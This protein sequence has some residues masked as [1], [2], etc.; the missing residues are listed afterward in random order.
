MD[1]YAPY[2]A[3]IRRLLAGEPRRLLGWQPAQRSLE[4][5]ARW[6][7]EHSPPTAG[8]WDASAR[9][10]YGVLAAWG[11]GHVL[12]YV[13]QR[14]VVQDNFGD[15]VGVRNFALAEAYFAQ[16]SEEQALRI[17]RELR[18]RYVLVRASGSGHSAGYGARSQFARL[19]ELRGAE[20]VFGGAPGAREQRIRALAHHRLIF[21]AEAVAGLSAGSRPSYKIFEIV[22]GA[23]IAGRALPGAE[24]RAELR[25][26]LGRRGRIAFSITALADADG[27]YELVVPYAN[28]PTDREIRPARAYRLRSGGREASLAVSD[29]EVLGG[30]Q[31][32]A[33]P[34]AG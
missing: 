19:Y 29:A 6:L 8:F 25:I 13:A 22:P 33:P 28:D 34:L 31:I 3:N 23:R 1:F 30:A 21:D 9:P 12:R 18:V 14:P 5:V 20:G 2:V 26:A 24:V 16:E 32:E 11:D 15:D 7:A 17:A 4:A 10:E 27:R